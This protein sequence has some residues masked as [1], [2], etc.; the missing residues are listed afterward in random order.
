MDASICLIESKL[1]NQYIITF[2]GANRML[3]YYQKGTH[4]IQTLKGNRKTIGGI[5]PDVDQEFVNNRIYLSPGDIIFL[6]SDGI[7]DQNN[8]NRKKYTAARFHT[9]LLTNID[10]PMNEMGVEVYRMFEN[11]KSSAF[12]RDDITVLGMRLLD[13][14]D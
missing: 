9:S 12:Q 2:A 14:K 1:K 7:V 13:D 6:N 3:Y 11:F 5:M 4:N 10:K 8:E